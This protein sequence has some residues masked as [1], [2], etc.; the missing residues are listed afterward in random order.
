MKVE[1]VD[2]ADDGSPDI[3]VDENGRH[4]RYFTDARDGTFAVNRIDH[5]CGIPPRGERMKT[6]KD[7]AALDL[8]IRNV[9]S[10]MW[11]DEM[12]DAQEQLDEGN[13]LVTL[14]NHLD[15]TAKAAETFLVVE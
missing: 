1:V 12:E 10:Y 15:G 11:D 7:V 13:D 2:R 9:I 5:P 6:K 14:Q 4:W 8:A 3:M